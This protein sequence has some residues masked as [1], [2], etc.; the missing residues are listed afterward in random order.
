MCVSLSICIIM[1]VISRS[2]SLDFLALVIISN[3]FF[4]FHFGIYLHHPEIVTDVMFDGCNQ[5]IHHA[6]L[7]FI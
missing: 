1:S 6:K 2:Y 3:I 4:S 5:I 7:K